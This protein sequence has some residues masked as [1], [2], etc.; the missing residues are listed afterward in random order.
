LVAFLGRAKVKRRSAG[1]LETPLLWV[2][3]CDPPKEGLS[4]AFLVGAIRGFTGAKARIARIVRNRKRHKS[5]RI[6]VLSR[7]DSRRL[8]HSLFPL[9]AGRFADSAGMPLSP[10]G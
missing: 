3:L 5:F 1:L 2:R 4:S 9:F 6:S 7:S 10:W 8:H